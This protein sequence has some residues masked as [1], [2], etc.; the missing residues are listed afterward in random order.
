MKTRKPLQNKVT[1]NHFKFE[2]RSKITQTKN[3]TVRVFCDCRKSE[4]SQAQ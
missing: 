2:K 1:A 3:R 4:E